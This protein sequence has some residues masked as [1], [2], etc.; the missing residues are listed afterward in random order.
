LN[1]RWLLVLPCLLTACVGFAA[2]ILP[3]SEYGAKPP[4]VLLIVLDDFGYNDLHAIGNLESPTPN[5][6]A[7]AAQETWYS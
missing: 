2:G 1:Y 5:L 6:D 4:D 3:P 7:L